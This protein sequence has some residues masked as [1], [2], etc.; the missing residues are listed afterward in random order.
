MQK[1]FGL[2]T[3]P[4]GTEADEPLQA[5][6][7]TK[8]HGKLLKIILKLEG[9]EVPG[10]NAKRWKAE[11]ENRKVTRKERKR[12]REEFEIGGFMAQKRLW[13]IAKNECW[14]RGEL[15]LRRET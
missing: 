1:A 4:C 9:G 12:A 6:K 2:C 10:R 14:K 8:E 5:R 15:C 11:G 3:L 13:N 7:D